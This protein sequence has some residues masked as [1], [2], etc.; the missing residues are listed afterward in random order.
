MKT[1]RKILFTIFFLAV[2]CV[3]C[4]IAK[5][6][7]PHN[8]ITLKDDHSDTTFVINSTTGKYRLYSAKDDVQYVGTID[9]SFAVKPSDCTFSIRFLDIKYKFNL[10]IE[11]ANA[12]TETGKVTLTDA[13]SIYMIDDTNNA[14]TPAPIIVTPPVIVPTP[15]TSKVLCIVSS[16]SKYQFSIDIGTGTYFLYKFNGKKPTNLTTGIAAVK[17]KAGK[18][19]VTING[20]IAKG[21][22]VFIAATDVANGTVTFASGASVPLT[23]SH[24]SMNTCLEKFSL[25][26]GIN[27]AMKKKLGNQGH[28]GCGPYVPQLEK[29]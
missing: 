10:T 23:S 21:K 29:H 16:T 12:C 27:K 15:P 13:T 6:Q 28:C 11:N 20:S 4:G 14:V 25:L 1:A 7:T 9:A 17:T 2:M 19:E 3:C 5:S 18:I 22:I 8:P 26:S 24:F